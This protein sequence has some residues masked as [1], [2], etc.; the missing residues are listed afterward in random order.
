[1]YQN[2]NTSQQI[3]HHIPLFAYMRTVQQNFRKLMRT[4]I[5]PK[6]KLVHDTAD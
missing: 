5:I 6:D 4:L 1:M 2:L 3:G